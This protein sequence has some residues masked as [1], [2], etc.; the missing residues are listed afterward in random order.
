LKSGRSYFATVTLA[1][2]ILLAAFGLYVWITGRHLTISRDQIAL[3][4]RSA[5]PMVGQTAPEVSLTALSGSTLTI[6]QV[7]GHPL[8]INYWATWCEPC[9][10]EMPLLQRSYE[11]YGPGLM[12]LAVNGGEDADDVAPFVD[13][14]GLT[15]PILLDPEYKAE[16]AFGVM[17]YPTTIFVDSDGI[18]QARQIGQLNA[19]LLDAYLELIGVGN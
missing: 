4:A 7:R 5:D 11:K 12:V 8:V 16:A 19:R 15:F 9:K 18:I 17:A 3:S 1:A 2:G 13:D 14:L 10:A 6:S